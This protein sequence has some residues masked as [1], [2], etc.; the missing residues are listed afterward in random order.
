MRH[1]PFILDLVEFERNEEVAEYS[2]FPDEGVNGCST[3]RTEACGGCG[4]EMCLVQE[5]Q[6]VLDWH[7]KFM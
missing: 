2:G 3:N 5:V 6:N 7:A 4:K 1:D